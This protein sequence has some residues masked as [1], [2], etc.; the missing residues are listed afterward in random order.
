VSLYH[1]GENI[2]RAVLRR[3]VGLPPD[4]APPAPRPG[5]H[6][7]LVDWI[8]DDPAPTESLDSLP[9]V[10]W[11]MAD[12]WERRSQ[13]NVL[14]VRYADLE[15]DLEGAM[16][17]LAARLRIEVDEPAWPALVRAASFS[18]MR[19]RAGAVLPD[20]NGILRDPAA[21]FRR[22]GSGAAREV[23]SAPELH[24]Y[25]E[26]AGWLAPADLLGWLHR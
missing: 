16:R 19:A 13:P 4:D 14:L 1:Q 20:R 9:G 6:D 25:E 23:L 8:E 5:L 17:E 3:L 7:W 26:R 2:D 10:M 21:F 18:E 15:R 12:A 22:G 24:R 11:H